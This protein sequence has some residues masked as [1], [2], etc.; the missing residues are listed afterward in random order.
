MTGQPPA[1]SI[2][3]EQV[4][5]ALRRSNAETEKFIAERHKLDAEAAKF[6]WDRYA[7]LVLAVAAFIGA[8]ISLAKS[9]NWIS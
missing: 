6:Q 9:F 3:Y 8:G 4:L 1:P 7:A 2:E 5:A